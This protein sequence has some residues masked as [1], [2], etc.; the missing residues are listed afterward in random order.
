MWLVLLLHNKT[1]TFFANYL[2][3]QSSG[4][5][6]ESTRNIRVT[7]P[8]L[9]YALFMEGFRQYAVRKGSVR[10][11]QKSCYIVRRQHILLLKCAS[12]IKKIQFILDISSFRSFNMDYWDQITIQIIKQTQPNK[13]YQEWLCLW[14]P[15]IVF[16]YIFFML[17]ETPIKVEFVG[18]RYAIR[19]AKI[20]SCVERRLKMKQYARRG[21]LISNID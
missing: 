9:W 7:P 15:Q 20:R 21:G 18:K 11:T 12:F 19:K 17:M 13:R 8:T 1:S 4:P 2:L 6:I 16:F 5:K 3:W 10:S 14:M